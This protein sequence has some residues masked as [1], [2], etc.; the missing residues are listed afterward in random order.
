MVVRIPMMCKEER[1]GRRRGE[2]GAAEKKRGMQ[3]SGRKNEEGGM[4]LISKRYKV[5]VS[6]PLRLPAESRCPTQPSL[7]F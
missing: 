7:H 2:G 3:E 1:G 5:C 4:K 6:F